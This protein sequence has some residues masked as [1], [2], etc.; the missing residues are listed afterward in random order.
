MKKKLIA[1]VMT[2][3]LAGGIGSTAIYNYNNNN[4]ITASESY[5]L[6]DGESNSQNNED[7]VLENVANND[8]NI[9]ENLDNSVENNNSEEGTSILPEDVS[10]QNNTKES[11]VDRAANNEAP[12]Q[13]ASLSSNAGNSN[14]NVSNNVI[15]QSTADSFMVQVEQLIYNKVNQER[16]AH[17]VAALSNSTSMQKYARIKS[18][19]MGDNNYFAHEDLNGNLITSKMKNDGVTYSA[20]GE[21][22]AYISGITDANALADQFMTNWMNSEG[23]R[24]NILSSN[25]SS[26]G[27]GVYKIGNKVYATQEFCR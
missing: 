24:K 16:S 12:L 9:I 8:E 23:H 19:D 11:S 6:N 22:I 7:I 4:K 25:F 27:I 13:S 2:T 20:W 18:Q 21:N 26:I 3:L 14:N 15:S 17:G 1:I 10:V 5:E